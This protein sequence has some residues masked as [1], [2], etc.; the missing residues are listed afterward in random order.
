MHGD[1][2]VGGGSN[3]HYLFFMTQLL[4]MSEF[5]GSWLRCAHVPFIKHAHLHGRD[6]ACDDA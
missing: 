3:V 1:Q 2:L 5:C 6:R 4:L